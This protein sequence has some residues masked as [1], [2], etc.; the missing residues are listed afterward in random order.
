MKTKNHK[1]SQEVSERQRLAAKKA[2]ITIRFLG[3]CWR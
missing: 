2:W 3:P 1:P